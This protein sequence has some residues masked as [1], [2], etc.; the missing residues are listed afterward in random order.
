MVNQSLSV[1]KR[2]DVLLNEYT[3]C[4]SN[5]DHYD[6]IR[7]TIVSI[8]GGAS[9]ATFGISFLDPVRGNPY[10][11][12]SLA[13]F[14]VILLVI[15]WAYYQHVNPWVNLSLIR[16]FQVENELRSLGFN[17]QLHYQIRANDNA[18]FKFRGLWITI[19]LYLTII[20]II[21]MLG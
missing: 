13:A 6:S 10:A 19:L 2:I 5:R 20:I 3:A 18:H 21:V 14:S 4:H 8:F 17:I 11:V 9:I 7:W 1:D 12:G 16:T 15:S